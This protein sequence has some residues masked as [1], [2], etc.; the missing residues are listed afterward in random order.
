M[1][2]PLGDRV[3]IRPLQPDQPASSVIVLTDPGPEVIGEVVS[4][5]R[6]PEETITRLQAVLTA[7][8]DSVASLPRADSADL[9]TGCV[10]LSDVWRLLETARF[11]LEPAHVV[12]P[13]DLVLFGAEAGNEVE[14]DDERL[15]MMREQDIKAVVEDN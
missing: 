2:R 9:G 1:L 15:L 4:V 3:L 6:G 8:Q 7:L 10:R 13:G 5:G 12:K 11:R 14:L